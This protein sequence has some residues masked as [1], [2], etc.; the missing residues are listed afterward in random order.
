MKLISWSTYQ[1]SLKQID[2]AA[3]VHLP[4]DQLEAGDLPFGLPVG[5][6]RHFASPLPKTDP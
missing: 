1:P 2:I 4:S 3:T 5:P 6:G